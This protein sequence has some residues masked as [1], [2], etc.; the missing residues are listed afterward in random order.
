MFRPLVVLGLLS[1]TPAFADDSHSGPDHNQIDGVRFDVHVNLDQYS[2]FGAGGRVEF[3]IV[4]DGF[5]RGKVRDELA[6]S[7]GADLFFTP[8]Y[9]GASG[10]YGGAYV[11]PIGVAQW[12][13]YLGEH[14]SVFPELGVALHVGFERDGWKDKHGNA[15]GWLYAAPAIGVGARYH[16]TSRVALLMRISTPGGVQVGVTF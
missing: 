15:Y 3:A 6:L 13:F 5:I 7:F 2:M 8:T 14:W 4:P 1:A 9:L 10:Y 16:F 11:I 12:N